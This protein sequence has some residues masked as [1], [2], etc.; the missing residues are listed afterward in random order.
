MPLAA[1]VPLTGCRRVASA[2]PGGRYRAT[3]GEAHYLLNRMATALANRAMPSGLSTTAISTR[4]RA[5]CPTT[6]TDNTFTH[7]G[8]TA[9][10]VDGACHQRAPRV[11]VR[12][13]YLPHRRQ[14]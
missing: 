11:N 2:S 12:R 13:P 5:P 9:R 8:L 1:L 6:L 14:A 3:T 7:G 10:S 4:R